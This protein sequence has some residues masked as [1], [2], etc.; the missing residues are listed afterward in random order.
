MGNQIHF[1]NKFHTHIFPKY[2]K[3]F[4]SQYNYQNTFHQHKLLTFACRKNAKKEKSV[5]NRIAA[6]RFPHHKIKK[7]NLPEENAE[8]AKY[9]TPFKYTAEE[10]ELEAAKI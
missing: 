7:I 6:R 3:T 4:I 10:S 8:L 5:R 1:T 2:S 9:I